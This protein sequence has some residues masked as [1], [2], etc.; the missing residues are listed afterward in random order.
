MKTIIATLVTV[1]VIALIVGA[2][3]FYIIRQKKKGVK[4]IGCP[5]AGNCPSGK[6]GCCSGTDAEKYDNE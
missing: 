6:M 1:L 2:A 5:G 3:A 4:C